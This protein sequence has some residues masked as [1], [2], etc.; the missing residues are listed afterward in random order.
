[1]SGDISLGDEA[2]LEWVFD[3]REHGRKLLVAM[4]WIALAFFFSWDT[5]GWTMIMSWGV[6]A[7]WE[8]LSVLLPHWPS[9]QRRMGQQWRAR[10]AASA[11]RNHR[12]GPDG[13]S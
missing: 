8:F 10:R 2:E 6:W 1:Y 13:L 4:G 11:R 12:K 7:A 3:V 5:V 9:V